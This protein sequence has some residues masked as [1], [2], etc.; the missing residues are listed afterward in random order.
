MSVCSNGSS[1]SVSVFGQDDVDLERA[2]DENYY[3][4]SC[5]LPPRQ[6]SPPQ[7]PQ[8]P[9]QSPQRKRST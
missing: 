2:C 7:N 9:P 6:P 8:S 5:V 1:Q 3:T 4:K